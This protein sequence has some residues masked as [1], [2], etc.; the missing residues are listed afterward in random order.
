[1]VSF[2]KL[3]LAGAASALFSAVC[4]MPAGEAGNGNGALGA[5]IATPEEVKPRAPEA[6]PIVPME[7]TAVARSLGGA[8]DD[9]TKR[10]DIRMRLWWAQGGQVMFL[11][12][13]NLNAQ[14]LPVELQNIIQGL[15]EGT[16]G[17]MLLRNFYNFIRQGHADL[18]EWL[19]EQVPGAGGQM[20]AIWGTA[21]RAG[22][23]GFAFNLPGGLTG[24]GTAGRAF[25]D[26]L[27][28]AIGEWAA[29]NGAGGM[30]SQQERANGFFN[31]ADI[32]GGPAP[33]KKRMAT[34][35]E[36]RK[37]S[38]TGQCPARDY[39]VFSIANEVIPNDV[40]FKRYYRWVNP[41]P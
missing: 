30:L 13:R 7:E 36:E 24:P 12:G 14:G 10:A 38:R 17:Q 18:Y 19:T 6:L 1:M 23:F 41:C 40:D 37:R 21:A 3:V 5:R 34:K 2:K 16:P 9:L 31:P 20:G 28:G 29:Q 22:D 39:N 33:G 32:G 35:V 26:M 25:L 4:A 8:D 27:V 11:L 15:G